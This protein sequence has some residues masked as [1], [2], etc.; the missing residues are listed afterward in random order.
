MGIDGLGGAVDGARHGHRQ[1]RG[2]VDGARGEVNDAHMFPGA[3][4]PRTCECGDVI[5]QQGL[6]L[7]RVRRL[8]I[9]QYG[10][11]ELWGAN[12]D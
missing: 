7:L 6:H 12:A 1:P 10:K 2:M 8:A 9:P 11:R 3:E 4:H 5:R